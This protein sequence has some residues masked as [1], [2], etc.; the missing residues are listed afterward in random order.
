MDILVFL[1]I[2]RRLAQV[3]PKA[4]VT[5]LFAAWLLVYPGGPEG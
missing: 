2:E 5:C 3:R 1:A 4:S